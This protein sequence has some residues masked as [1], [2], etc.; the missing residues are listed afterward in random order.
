MSFIVIEGLDGSGKSTQVKR[1][2][3]YLKETNANFEYLH[4]PVTEEQNF[5]L[6]VS[7]FLRGELGDIDSVDPWVVAMLFAGNRWALANKIRNW[8]ENKT[9]VIVDRYV[10]S[11]IAYQVAKV[12]ESDN[13]R[14]LRNWI[15]SLEYET[16]KIPKPDINIWLD[17]PITFVETQLSSKRS[18]D[19]RGYL[20]GVDD[21]HE[22]VP[23]QKLVYNEYED[24]CA[25][26]PDL[27]R[28]KCHDNIGNME[29]ENT[30]FRKLL[31]TITHKI[32]TI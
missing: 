6:L 5:G 25:E 11:N 18:G 15:Y 7:R 1:L 17:A 16:F 2:C 30:I 29:D 24:C 3:S 9:L 23:F 12:K 26:Y 8:L 19:D 21:I 13:K 10:Y 32:G 4:F 27:I 20:Q 14:K 31:N 22:T 28:V